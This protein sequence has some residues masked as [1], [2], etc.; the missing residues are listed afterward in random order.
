MTWLATALLF[1]VLVYCLRYGLFGTADHPS[2]NG[3][4]LSA[5]SPAV[6]TGSRSE[7]GIPPIESALA[8]RDIAIERAN[9]PRQD[10]TAKSSASVPQSVDRS[11]EVAKQ[12]DGSDGSQLPKNSV[13]TSDAAIDRPFPVS[14][15]VMATCK[16]YDAEWERN[17]A[18]GGDSPWTCSKLN[19]LLPKLAEER[20]D[21]VWATRMEG[22]FRELIMAEA[23]NFEIRAIECRTSM[24]AVECASL[25][26]LLPDPPYEFRR[27]NQLKTAERMWGYEIGPAGARVTVTLAVY[28]RR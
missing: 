22:K 5:R 7:P 24:C 2:Q 19:E 20:R 8:R 3:A 1:L 23:G 18:L 17:P 4:G 27:D 11:P 9:M 13:A 21:E 16:K 10:Q 6:V 25:D 12:N 28:T 15:S 14:D 26:G